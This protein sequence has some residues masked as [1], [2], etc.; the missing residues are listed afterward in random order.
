MARITKATVE[1][2]KPPAVGQKFV[3]DSELR[4]FALRVTANGAKSF[5]WEGRVS[6]VNRRMTLGP[7]PALSVQA[8]RDEAFARK[9]DVARGLDPVRE[10]KN[11]RAVATFRELAA[12]YIEEHAKPN[13][14]SWREDE[15]R[16]NS[17]LLPRSRR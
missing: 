5:I 1:N 4:G 14:R 2:I 3:R 6:G 12:T 10:R 7:Y 9:A 8:A 17:H 13:K 11:K 15:R 16:I